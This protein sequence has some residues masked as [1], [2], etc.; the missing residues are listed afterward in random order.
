MTKRNIGEISNKY[1]ELGL[2]ESELLDSVVCLSVSE[3]ATCLGVHYNTA[4]AL[5]TSGKIESIRPTHDSEDDKRSSYKVTLKTL[6]DY[7]QNKVHRPTSRK[8]SV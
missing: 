7:L 3:V 5:I 6:K 2:S 4:Y 1:Q 8:V